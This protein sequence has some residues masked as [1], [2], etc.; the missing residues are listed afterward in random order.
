MAT[1]FQACPR[2]ILSSKHLQGSKVQTADKSISV[3]LTDVPAAVKGQRAWGH[4]EAGGPLQPEAGPPGRHPAS[5]TSLPAG[6]DPSIRPQHSSHP[7]RFISI[8]IYFSH[9]ISLSFCLCVPLP[10]F[11]S[12]SSVRTHCFSPSLPPYIS[13]TLFLCMEQSNVCITQQRCERNQTLL[14][15]PT[16][17]ES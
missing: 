5:G 7:C 11:L 3:I 12:V 17:S 1:F 16:S 15:S 4:L 10:L 9:S 6:P 14:S 8:F 2:V 13:P